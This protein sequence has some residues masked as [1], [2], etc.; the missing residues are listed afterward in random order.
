[1]AT[2]LRS[3]RDKFRRGA[4]ARNENDLQK[5]IG[6]PMS[7]SIGLPVELV[8]IVGSMLA[9]ED[10]LAFS[11]C[12][13]TLFNIFPLP[14]KLCRQQKQDLL[15]RI[16]RDVG[17]TYSFCSYCTILHKFTTA[18]GAHIDQDFLRAEC[19]SGRFLPLY[20]WTRGN[21]ALSYQI[22]RLLA[23]NHRLGSPIGIAASDL[24]WEDRYPSKFSTGL[25]LSPPSWRVTLEARFINNQLLLQA[26]HQIQGKDWNDLVRNDLAKAR[27]QLCEHVFVFERYPPRRWINKE[28]AINFPSPH[29]PPSGPAAIRTTK[30]CKVCLADWNIDYKV[31][32]TELVTVTI[33]TYHLL[34]DISSHL[35]PAWLLIVDRGCQVPRDQA[36]AI[37]RKYKQGTVRDL[38]Q[39]AVAQLPNTCSGAKGASARQTRIHMGYSCIVQGVGYHQL[40]ICSF[41][42]S[43]VRHDFVSC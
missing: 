35:D 41:L 37:W 14:Q 21:R 15:E 20:A 9:P 22:A 27:H 13:K 33:Q 36:V 5:E 26:T 12:C 18:F 6:R 23:N 11:L 40:P 34:G 31:Y 32:G 8:L 2:I 10:V 1:M 38:W 25:S 7:T 28:V 24:C 43:C 30:G 16:E 4:G 3:I 39:E 17:Q 19:C 29:Q 42:A